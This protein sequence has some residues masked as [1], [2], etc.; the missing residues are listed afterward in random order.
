MTLSI[1]HQDWQPLPVISNVRAFAIGD[2][3]GVS[4]PLKAAFGEIAERAAKGGPDHLIMLGDYIDRGPDS[5]GVIA[6]ILQGI[7]GVRITALAGNHEGALAAAVDSG[8]IHD[9][10]VWLAN[11]GWTV[12]KEL[13]LPRFATMDQVW[14]ALNGAERAFIDGLKPYHLED[15][16]LFVHGGINPHS[17]VEKSLALPW[18]HIPRTDREA[19]YSPFWVREPFL[20]ADANPG[21]LF[22]IH[23]HTPEALSQPVMTSHRLGL[24]IGSSYN[25]R[26]ALAEI[27][28]D[29]VRL[30]VIEDSE[31]PARWKVTVNR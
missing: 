10:R 8:E 1:T 25:G 7:P 30:T 20:L 14:A 31:Q 19:R 29:R 17:N 27:D 24:D 5:R 18:R 21:G 13:G 11:G 23:G 3:H 2:V 9:R 6:T 22:V 26:I 12:L 4:A 28:M 15:G 16:L